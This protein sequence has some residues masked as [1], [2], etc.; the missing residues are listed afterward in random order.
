MLTGDTLFV[1]AVGRPDL[2]GRA[3][4]NAG[5][6][7][8]SLHATLPTLPADVEIYPGHFSGSLCGAGLSGKPTSTIAF[9]RR[10]NPM[11]SLTRD[12]FN[13]RHAGTQVPV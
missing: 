7:Y 10:R 4:E 3:R 13:R 12:A 9:E 11:L 8:T 5:E 1:G 6:L 2:P